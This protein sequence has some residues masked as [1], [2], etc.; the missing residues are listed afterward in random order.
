MPLRLGPSRGNAARASCTCHVAVPN[1]SIKKK[2]SVKHRWRTRTVGGHTE[3]AL[4]SRGPLR[5]RRSRKLQQLS[6]LNALLK[7]PSR[8]P[9][10]AFYIE[11]RSFSD[12]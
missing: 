1:V 7:A 2:V 5:P 4:T 8:L 10:S 6:P 12:R 11:A 3:V 9:A